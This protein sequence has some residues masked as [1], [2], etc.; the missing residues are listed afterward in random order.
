[1]ANLITNTD[2][3][4]LDCLNKSEK[5]LNKTEIVYEIKTAPKISNRRVNYLEGIKLIKKQ[6]NRFVLNKINSNEQFIA[7]LIK[8][9]KYVLNN[10]KLSS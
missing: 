8:K 9:F 6:K 1:M 5:P 2:I 7:E 3:K 10:K 4:I